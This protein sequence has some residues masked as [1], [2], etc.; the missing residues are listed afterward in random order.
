M[1]DFFDRLAARHDPV[2]GP[3]RLRPRLPGPFERVDSLPAA[4]SDSEAPA[5]RTP[6]PSPVREREVRRLERE[7]RTTDRITLVRTEASPVER[8]RPAETPVRQEEPESGPRP[9]V[10]AR[11][12]QPEQPRGVQAASGEPEPAAPVPERGGALRAAVLPPAPAESPRTR[13]T[14]AASAPRTAPARSRASEPADPAVRVEI[15]R[16][17]V[18][19]A[20]PQRPPHRP[21]PARREPAVNLDDYLDGRAIS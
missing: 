6:S 5:A 21:R 16:L 4:S 12:T 10:P 19:A 20:P 1:A 15:G 8:P 11:A 17:Q 2:D 9:V 14:A 7:V 18:S 3:V 13:I